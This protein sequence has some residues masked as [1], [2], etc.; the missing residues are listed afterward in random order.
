MKLKAYFLSLFILISFVYMTE[1]AQAKYTGRLVKGTWRKSWDNRL[2]H[3]IHDVY[4]TDFVDHHEGQID[5]LCPGYKSSNAKREV[6]W[7]QL[8][9]SLAWKESLHGPRNW[10]NFNGGK[11]IGLYQINPVLRG[12]YGCG[13]VDLYDAINNI[14]CGVKMARHLINKYG[15]FL[16]GRKSGMAAYWQPLRATSNYNRR[17]RSRILSEVTN[18]CKTGQVKYIST[19]STLV[20]MFEDMLKGRTVNTI[21]DLPVEHLE[22]VLWDH[23]DA[24]DGERRSDEPVPFSQ[25]S[26]QKIELEPDYRPH[27]INEDEQ[28]MIDEARGPIEI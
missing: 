25:E 7:H 5:Q 10:V 6:F 20:W 9:V 3:L 24:L 27:F 16:Q 21:H 28:Q 12:A 15:S 18:A 4:R 8:F 13:R 26:D 17:N 14:N 11:N 23:P 1:E 2:K 19:N 22:K